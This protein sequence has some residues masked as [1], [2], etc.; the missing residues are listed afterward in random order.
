[1]TTEIVAAPNLQNESFVANTSRYIASPIVYWS[2]RRI[3]TFATY[4]RPLNV[5]SQND[6]YM[7]IKKGME[8]RP[9]LIAKAA[10]GTNLISF[11]W[12]IMEA[13][14][15]FDVFDLKAGTTLRV[16]SVI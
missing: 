12:K 13:N 1:M 6:K 8:F 2:E 4:K 14:N 5:V 7:L 10:Y 15:I 9:D 16:P 3:I 11:W